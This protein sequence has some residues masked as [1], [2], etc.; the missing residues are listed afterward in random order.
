MCSKTYTYRVT[1]LDKEQSRTDHHTARAISLHMEQSYTVLCRTLF[2]WRSYL[3]SMERSKFVLSL[4]TKPA[5]LQMVQAIP[6]LEPP[7]CAGSQ[8]FTKVIAR[9]TS[10]YGESS[11]APTFR[12]YMSKELP[13]HVASF[14]LT[15]LLVLQGELPPPDGE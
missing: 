11:V 3:P 7:P 14:D 8:D 13:P 5:S 4:R 6:D 15:A 9:V 12:Q 1:S 10:P 2:T